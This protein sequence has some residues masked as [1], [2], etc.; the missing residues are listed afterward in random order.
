MSRMDLDMR[1]VRYFVAV[2]EECSFVRAASRLYM[3]Q[4]ALSRQI[5]ALEEDLGVVLFL[6]D[7]Q[8]TVLTRAG[9]Q[10]LEDARPMLAMSQAVQQRVRTANRE[11]N[12]FAVGFMPGIVVTPIVREFAAMAPQLEIEVVHTSI[13][14]QVDFLIDGRVDVCYVR[15]P[16]PEGMFEV[17]PLFPEPRVVALPRAHPCAELKAVHVEDLRDMVL[18]QDPQDVPEWRGRLPRAPLAQQTDAGRFPVTIEECLEGVASG[19]GCYVMP[20]GMAGFY[21]RDD[22]AYLTLEGVAPRMVALAYS[23]HRSMPELNQ[24]AELSRRMLGP[25]P[26]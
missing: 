10:L 11:V 24:F 5:R 21:R 17:V 15:L 23:K 4:P 7:R 3:T 1:R 9:H 14:D 26:E 13:S 19:A 20:A 12:H 16:L 6:R 8:G 18:L 2:A 25:G 22:I